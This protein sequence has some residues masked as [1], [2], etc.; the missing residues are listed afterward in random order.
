MA[1]SMSFQAGDWVRELPAEHFQPCYCCLC[2]PPSGERPVFQVEGVV[3]ESGRAYL[4]L[5]DEGEF[6][7]DEF[8][9]VSAPAVRPGGARR[10][11][12]RVDLRGLG[13]PE[14]LRHFLSVRAS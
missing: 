11:S 2:K 1:Y 12:A 5:V 14:S 6:P 13:G 4:V 8:E 9:R 7:A 3:E 10:E